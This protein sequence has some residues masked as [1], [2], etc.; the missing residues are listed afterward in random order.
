[1]GLEGVGGRCHAARLKTGLTVPT[2]ARKLGV[3]DR[4]LQR[5]ERGI[6]EPGLKA[7][8]R[9]AELY[10]VTTDALIRGRARAA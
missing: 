7:I 8:D 10:K 3:S 1:M 2:A 4:T 5:W 6:Y 9:M